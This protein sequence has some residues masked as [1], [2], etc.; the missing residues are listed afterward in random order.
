MLCVQSPKIALKYFFQQCLLVSKLPT[1]IV[2]F[3]YSWPSIPLGSAP[4]DSTNPR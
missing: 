3:E 4:T 2:I 1:L